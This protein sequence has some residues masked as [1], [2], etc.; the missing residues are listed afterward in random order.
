MNAR[1]NSRPLAARPQ[2][3]IARLIGLA[4][5]A[6]GLAAS[7]AQ[8]QTLNWTNGAGGSAATI[9]NW[10]PNQLPNASSLLVW[11][12]AN[13]YTVTWNSS[14]TASNSH[15]LKKGVV[16]YTLSSPHTIGAGGL[17]VGDVSGDAA[18]LTLTTGTLNSVGTAIVGN[19]SGS[20]GTLNVNDDDAELIITGATGDLT[21]A[22]N[23]P[24]VLNVTGGGLVQVSDQFIGGNN[25]TGASTITISGATN[26]L[27]LTR[28]RLI[29]NGIG[30]SS[31]FGQGGDATVAISNGA[32]A[33]FAG[34]LVVSNGSASA[35]AVTVA[36]LGGLV[37]TEAEL[38]V[39]GD[40]LL[41][42]N[43]S[44]GT[45]AGAATL[46]INADGLVGVGGTLFVGGDPDG[47]S[48]VLHTATG[49]VVTADSLDIGVG[50]TLDLDG[51]LI[52]I[53]GG[54]LTNST[55]ATLDINGA[56]GNP[57]VTMKNGATATLPSFSGAG[58]RVGT[59]TGANLADVNV[60]SGSDLVVNGNLLM[61]VGNDDFGGMIVNGAGSSLSNP[62]SIIVAGIA[63]DARLE[64]DMGASM[65]GHELWIARDSASSAGVLFEGPG[66]TAQFDAVYVGGSDV[67][68]GGDGN[69]SVNADAVLTIPGGG[70]LKVWNNGKLDVAQ[71]AVVNLAGGADLVVLGEADLEDGA[72]VNADVAEF[73]A[74]S[75]LRGPNNVPGASTLNAK[76]L[77][78][79]GAT[80][81]LVAGDL[82]IGDSASVSGFLADDGSVINVGAHTL[83]LLD[84]DRAE[85]DDVTI[86]GGEI[87]APNGFEIVTLVQNGHL[88]GTG[89]ITGEVFMETGAS[90]ITSTGANGLTINGR[91]RNNSGNIDGTRYTFNHNPNLSSS[92]WTGAGAINARVTFNS[93]TTVFAI[94]NMTLGA[95]VTDGVVFNSGSTLDVDDEIVTL[96]DSNGV[97]LASVNKLDGGTIA[98]ATNLAL[99]NG[100]SIVGEGN[101]GCPT[102]NM[103]GGTIAPSFRIN[104]A[105]PIGSLTFNPSA[106]FVMSG[107]AHSPVA[108]DCDIAS[109]TNADHLRIESAATLDGTLNV[110]LINGF[111]MPRGSRV[112][113][114]SITGPLTGWFT[115]L[116]LPWGHRLIEFFTDETVLQ[117]FNCPP[118]VN[119]DG[120]V[121]GDDYDAFAS[122]FESGD[123]F[124]DFNEDGFVNGDDYDMFASEFEMGC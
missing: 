93:N 49:G 7:S 47:G 107:S 57:V 105:D 92:G 119:S 103:T 48:A 98:C 38:S 33:Q 9:T 37:P 4:G 86:N 2:S 96:V 117:V 108:Y 28:S 29:V 85:V 15:T 123:D 112:D 104:S 23:S 32:L 19:A 77:L 120:F 67:A 35:S 64:A 78:R 27:P 76:A 21:I 91:F 100:R 106:A 56:P 68:G 116:N 43:T 36:G 59:G 79:S 114:A 63:G 124:A 87:V 6:T 45:A 20:S 118:D 39:A 74:G 89:T 50:A 3:R 58:L 25:S 60:R 26:T 44:G 40:L 51:G 61:G 17:K 24:G 113:I 12:L 14:V 109:L 18:T 10:S 31:R 62:G 70:P 72:V 42:R 69:L 22:S 80:L 111:V 90:V 71:S 52:N 88:D 110:Q 13:T 30:T 46:N 95:S 41:G 83:T 81:D 121:N 122:A 65:T 84:S 53:D 101:I 11:N 73:R 102:F 97:T 55:G 82:T 1:P 16:T 34:D 8:A 94:A 115:T 5:L 54:T 66:T 75:I 99:T